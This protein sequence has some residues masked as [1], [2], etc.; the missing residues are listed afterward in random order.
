MFFATDTDA[1]SL[2]ASGERIR[3]F[4]AGV[5][6]ERQ[7][8]LLGWTFRFSSSEREVGGRFKK[9][10]VCP[11]PDVNNF[12]GLIFLWAMLL[13]TSQRSERE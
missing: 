9:T 1:E 11:G 7:K 10:A 5:D 2:E 13:D 4:P 3:V 6:H 12:S 8:V